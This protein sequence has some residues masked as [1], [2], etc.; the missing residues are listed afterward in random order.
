MIVKHIFK[1]YFAW[2]SRIIS[3]RYSLIE[4]NKT[5]W[6]ASSCFSEYIYLHIYNTALV[7]WYWCMYYYCQLCTILPF[8]PSSPRTTCEIMCRLSYLLLHVLT[9]SVPPFRTAVFRRCMKLSMRWWSQVIIQWTS[10]PGKRRMWILN[11]CFTY[12]RDV[13]LTVAVELTCKFSMYWDIERRG[14]DLTLIYFF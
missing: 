4:L 7:W 8:S 11:S 9:L 12:W 1:K 6:C 5:E 13:K 2:T 14:D 3:S 10:G